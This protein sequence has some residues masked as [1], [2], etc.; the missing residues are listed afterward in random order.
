MNQCLFFLLA[1]QKYSD[2]SDVAFPKALDL[3]LKIEDCLIG[4]GEII[5]TIMIDT[6][7]SISVIYIKLICMIV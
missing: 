1:F 6:L 2:F 5:S 3:E 4:I 7:Y